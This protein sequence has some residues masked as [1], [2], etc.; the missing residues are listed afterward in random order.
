MRK[1]TAPIA[2]LV[3]V[4]CGNPADD[5]LHPHLVGYAGTPQEVDLGPFVDWDHAWSEPLG[6]YYRMMAVPLIYE[7][8]ACAGQPMARGR[9]SAGFVS[10]ATGSVLRIPRDAKG[11]AMPARSVKTSTGC[12]ANDPG[13]DGSTRVEDATPIEDTGTAAVMALAAD[14]SVELR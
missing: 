6:A 1:L 10:S 11:R 2:V 4:A 13:A 9:M 3:L 5:H 7:A 8:D 14:L 12:R